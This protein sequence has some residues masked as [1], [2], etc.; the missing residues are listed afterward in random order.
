MVQTTIPETA[1]DQTI[2]WTLIGSASGVPTAVVVSSAVFR[3]GRRKDMDLPIDSPAVSGF[4]A[5]LLIANNALYVRDVGSTNGSFLNGV[6]IAS[7]TELRDGDCLDLGGTIFRIMRQTSDSVKP[8]QASVS[9]LK[10]S[11]LSDAVDAI[12]RRSLARLLSG[13]SLAPCYQAIH[14]LRTGDLAGYEFLARSCYPGIETAGQLFGQ[15]AKAGREIELSMLCRE[16]AFLHSKLLKTPVP[17]F[18]NTH[19][20]EPLLEIVLPQMRI[21][22]E[23]YPERG[24]VLEIH[25]GANTDPGLVRELRQQLAQIHVKLAFDDFGVGQA[26]I[27]EMIS[28]SADFIKFDPSLIRDL[29]SLTG[30]Q[31]R[32]FAT[33]IAGIKNEGTVTVAEGIETAEMAE[34]CHDVGFDLVQGYLY[35]RPTIMQ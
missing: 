32:F 17:V 14:D 8:P 1:P 9:A 29:Q 15:S 21:L 25:E 34:V 27:R 19:P 31:R 23:A 16:Q 28:A 26:R 11:F 4:H 3:I 5:E 6:R 35:S 7:E 10:T 22:R 30:D 12:G 24:M 20:A 2:K 13:G 33:I 18:V